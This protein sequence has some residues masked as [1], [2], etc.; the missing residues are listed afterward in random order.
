[1]K[2]LLFTGLGLM[3]VFAA[4]TQKFD[5]GEINGASYMICIPDNWNQG[6]IMYAHGY[7]EIGEESEA[8]EAELNE[9]LEIFTSRGFAF[10]ASSYKRQGLV[11]KDGI[12]DTEALRSYFEINYGKPELCIITG[13]SMGGIISLATIE[14]YPYEYDGALPLCAWLGPTSSLMKFGLDML[15]TCD[16]LFLEND[17]SL[18]KGDSEVDVELLDKKL[19]QDSE[20][21]GLF[22]EHFRI[23]VEDLAE[24]IAFYEYA[25]K[26]TQAWLGGIP[27]GNMQTIYSGFG[28]RNESLNKDIRRYKGFPDATEYFTQ[29]YSPTA[30]ISDPVLALHTTYDEILPVFNYKYYEEATLRN[31]TDH[32]FVQQYI[33]RDGHCYFSEEETGQALDQLLEWIKEGTRPSPVYN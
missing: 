33:V 9:F 31:R 27:M 1:M 32:L 8:F 4:Y 24:M 3:M 11:V 29:Y 5:L 18:V 30:L 6:L 15:V 13:H 16:Y 26:E 19:R 25:I 12:E 10:A 2:K 28:D 22:A 21:A 17:G 20:T 7:E 23:R 14:K